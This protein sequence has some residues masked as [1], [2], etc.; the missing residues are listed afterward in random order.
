MRIWAHRGS[1]GPEGPLEN[2]HAAFERAIVDGADGIELDV[3]LT[4]DGVPVVFHDETLSR[5]TAEADQRRV[6]QVNASELCS[7]N[8]IRGERIPTLEAVLDQC[9]GRIP[10]NIELKDPAG[11]DATARLLTGRAPDGV[12]ISSFA[13]HA[14]LAAAERLPSLPRALIVE[15]DDAA[16]SWSRTVAPYGTL[17]RVQA[18]HWHPHHALVWSELIHALHTIGIGV[19]AWTVN[20]PATA[21]RL[22]RCG[23]DGIMTDRPAWLRRGLAR[24]DPGR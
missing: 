11:V 19:T 9:L 22:R 1:Q 6:D 18:T 17:R 2:T 15:I 4:A 7:L 14:V 8:L 16:D 13:D 3:H 23:V 10:L 21:D 12:M 20:D 5:L 24:V